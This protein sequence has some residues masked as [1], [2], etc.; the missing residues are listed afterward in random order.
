MGGELGAIYLSLG[1]KEKLNWIEL[2]WGD[3]KNELNWGDLSQS[4]LLKKGEKG[5]ER[6]SGVAKIVMSIIFVGIVTEAD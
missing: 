3:L 4:L 5:K 6:D 1:E 2:N